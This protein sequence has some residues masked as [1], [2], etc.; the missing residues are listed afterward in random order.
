MQKLNWL[1]LVVVLVLGCSMG[2]QQVDS[3]AAGQDAESPKVFF[4]MEQFIAAEVARL[5]AEGLTLEKQIRYNGAEEVKTV[6][7]IDFEEELSL[8]RRADINKPAWVDLYKADTTLVNGQMS[9]VRYQTVD[10]ELEVKTL[11]VEWDAAGAVSAILIERKNSS[12][13]ATNEYDL[14]YWPAKGY[15]IETNQQNKAADPIHIQITGNFKRP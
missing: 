9:K 13:L 4:S 5:Q 14:S 12:T 3:A 1:V 15:E 2:C 11:E 10:P 8:F 6:S 7:N